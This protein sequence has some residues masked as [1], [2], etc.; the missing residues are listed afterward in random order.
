MKIQL[1][2]LQKSTV[3][4]APRTSVDAVEMEGTVWR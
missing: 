2:L 3:K 4:E 1:E